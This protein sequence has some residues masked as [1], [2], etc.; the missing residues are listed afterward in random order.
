MVAL[1]RAD[2]VRF[3]TAIHRGLGLAF[4]DRKVDK[5]ADVLD[6]R[7]QALDARTRADARTRHIP[8]ML[9]TSQNAPADRLR[10]QQAGAAAYVVKGEFDQAL[11]LQT[12]RKLVG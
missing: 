1:D 8:A 2:V 11:L 10:G 12:I 6:H 3:R 9:V 7:L 5:L 4:D